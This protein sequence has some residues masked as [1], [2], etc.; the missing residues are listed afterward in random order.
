MHTATING[1]TPKEN[2]DLWSTGPIHFVSIHTAGIIQKGP[3]SVS[4]IS[5][6]AIF[7]AL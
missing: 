1:R 4:G 2:L 5:S 3:L 7:Q 6:H